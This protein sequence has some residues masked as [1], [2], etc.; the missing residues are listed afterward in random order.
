M[1]KLMTIVAPVV[2]SENEK[3]VFAR[4]YVMGGDGIEPP[5]SWV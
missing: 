2:C 4:C 3:A 5:T 1:T